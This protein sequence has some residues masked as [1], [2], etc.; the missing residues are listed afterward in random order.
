MHC[1]LVLTQQIEK[2]LEAAGL[3]LLVARLFQAPIVEPLQRLGPLNE[4]PRPFGA[5]LDLVAIHN[6]LRCRI[7]AR[8]E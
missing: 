1:S 6:V 2:Q 5:L 8:A 7:S 3:A 4:V